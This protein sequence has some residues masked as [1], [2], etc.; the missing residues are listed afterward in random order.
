MSNKKKIPLVMCGALH[1]MAFVPVISLIPLT[2]EV[3][4]ATTFYRR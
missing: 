3:G 2:C 1:L 4:V